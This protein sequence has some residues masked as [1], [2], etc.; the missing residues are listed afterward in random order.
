MNCEI[1][2]V[3]DDW[4][5]KG[6]HVHVGRVEVSIHPDHLGGVCFDSPFSSTR[7]RDLEAATSSV[8][9]SLSDPEFRRQLRAA[10][11]RAQ[12]H[13]LSIQGL[14]QAKA[15]GRLLEFKYLILALDRM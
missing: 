8:R 4:A 9:E 2:A 6:C 1:S 7:M 5:S 11:E 3:S 12:V 10:I 14:W 15:R 13:M